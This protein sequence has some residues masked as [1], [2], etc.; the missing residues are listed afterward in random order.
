[1]KLA[2]VA[3][4]INGKSKVSCQCIASAIPEVFQNQKPLLGEARRAPT[5]GLPLAAQ[6]SPFC[7]PGVPA[8]ITEPAIHEIRQAL[9][10]LH[11]WRV[12]A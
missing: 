5:F 3:G 12:V 10:R 2:I 9:A 11:Q 8:G 6:E 7:R 4:E 1:M